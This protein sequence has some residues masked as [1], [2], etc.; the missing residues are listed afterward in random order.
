MILVQPFPIVADITPADLDNA[1][2]IITISICDNQLSGFAEIETIRRMQQHG[3]S[4]PEEKRSFRAVVE[5]YSRFEGWYDND[6]LEIYADRVSVRKRLDEL[7]GKDD[8]ASIMTSA[9]LRPM[10][11]RLPEHADYAV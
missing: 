5:G 11:E 2:L 10:I 8:F 6:Y 7:H 4:N 9:L 3:I 1:V